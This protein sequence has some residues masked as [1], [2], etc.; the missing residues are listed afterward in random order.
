MSDSEKP[1]GASS[2]L[3]S[4]VD[5]PPNPSKVTS[6]GDQAGEKQN[7]SWS[8]SMKMS[9]HSD[10][11]GS[12][13]NMDQLGSDKEDNTNDNPDC[14][15][16]DGDM[17]DEDENE[18]Q[19]LQDQRESKNDSSE[20][21]EEEDQGD[22][23][24]EDE[25]NVETSQIRRES[26]D[27][28]SSEDGS[29]HSSNKESESNDEDGEFHDANNGSDGEEDN[30]TDD[31]E[32]PSQEQSPNQY[33]VP[34]NIQPGT[35]YQNVDRDSRGFVPPGTI[36]QNVDNQG[37]S[38]AT[39]EDGVS[40]V[41]PPQVKTK[42]VQEG[43][44]YENFEPP[45]PPVPPRDKK[46]PPIPVK[47]YRSSMP[48]TMDSV[49]KS[50]D[51]VSSDQENTVR[52]D[53]STPAGDTW[54]GPGSATNN[55]AQ[56]SGIY[57]NP[58]NTQNVPN[59]QDFSSSLYG[60]PYSKEK[61]TPADNATQQGQGQQP[62]GPQYPHIGQ[63]HETNRP[64]YQSMGPEGIQHQYIPG[65]YGPYHQ[66]HPT[67]N[68]EHGE[69]TT[70]GHYPS[71]PPGP[72]GYTPWG[73][74]SG[75]MPS[76]P[77]PDFAKNPEAYRQWCDYM[78]QMQ[79]Q[80]QR[81]WHQ[82]HFP[83]HPPPQEASSMP[84]Q[85]SQPPRDTGRGES[86]HPPVQKPAKKP[87]PPR[88]SKQK[89]KDTQDSGT[90]GDPG[91]KPKKKKKDQGDVIVCS[92][93]S[94]LNLPAGAAGKNLV[95][96]GGDQIMDYIKTNY[97][98]PIDMGEV[99]VV[100]AGNLQ[101]QELYLG[102]LPQ[103]HS[104]KGKP[105]KTMYVFMEKC[106]QL[107]DQS[108]YTTIIFSALGTGQLKYPKDQ[109]ANLMYQSIIDFDQ[110]N[111]S[112]VREVQIICFHG[113]RDTCTVSFVLK[114]FTELISIV[115]NDMLHLHVK[116]PYE[117]K[118]KVKMTIVKEEIGKHKADI[119]V[120]AV[121]K[122]LDIR[123]SGASSRSIYDNGGA[124]LQEECAS[125]YPNGLSN[126][127][128][129]A[130]ISGGNLHC[131]EVL[132]TALPNEETKTQKTLCKFVYNCMEYADKKG[133]KSIG[134]PAVGT[135]KINYDRNMVAKNFYSQV[136]KY[137]DDNP[138]SNIKDVRFV[139]YPKDEETI[140]V[141]AIVCCGTDDL[142]LSRGKAM[143]ALLKEGG[144]SLQQECKTKYPNGIQP[145]GV[146]VISGGNLKSSH[147]YLG[148]LPRYGSGPQEAENVLKDF[149]KKCL[150]T[151]EKNRLKSIAFPC[152]GSGFNS[153][154]HDKSAALLYEAVVDFDSQH[155]STSLKT[156]FFVALSNDT[157]SLTV[158]CS[159]CLRNSYK[160]N[161]YKNI[162]VHCMCM[163]IAFLA[164][165]DKNRDGF[166]KFKEDAIGQ[167]FHR[168]LQKFVAKGSQSSVTKVQIVA[169]QVT[170]VNPLCKA[171]REECGKPVDSGIL[172]TLS[173]IAENVG[174]KPRTGVI[175]SKKSQA[176]SVTVWIYSD[177]HR[178][179]TD[180][181]KELDKLVTSR[182][183]NTDIPDTL[184]PDLKQNEIDQIEDIADKY[185]IE[186]KIDVPRSK[187]LIEGP[188]KD[189][190]SAKDEIYK[191]FRTFQHERFLDD[192]A[193]HFATMVQ[194][195]I[196]EYEQGVC[197]LE[198]YP[199]RINM[200]LENAYKNN[201]TDKVTLNANDGDLIVDLQ[202]MKE[203]PVSDPS[204]K[205][206]VVRKELL[207]GAK[208]ELP[209][210]WLVMKDTETVKVV[211]LQPS[212]Q[213][214]Q[215][216]EKKFV[217]SVKN[218]VY[219]TKCGNYPGNKRTPTAADHPIGQ[220]NNVKVMKIERIQNPSLYQQYV[221]K[222]VSME[223]SGNLPPN[224]DPEKELW[225]GT[226]ENII[227]SINYY[228]FNRSYC[229]Q[230]TKQEA[231][232]GNGVYFASDASYS[233]RDWVSQKAAGGKKYMYL[234]KV[235][236]GDPVVGQKGMR[237]LPP[238]PGLHGVIY[239][240]AVDYIKSPMEYVI[241]NDTQAYPEYCIEFTI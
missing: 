135:G 11:N 141:D 39:P 161:Y 96:V 189:V 154:P 118:N 45:A 157:K 126:Y 20:E 65:Q 162:H 201:N 114:L 107:A 143:Q 174:L 111:T 59:P 91:K 73:M 5:A 120:C 79:M 88:Q 234:V 44:V 89:T 190:S 211:P 150:E 40:Q 197:K 198:H 10:D 123:G 24:D 125:K 146:A 50:S 84:P 194:W 175:G 127:G 215:H 52:S 241:F 148:T 3:G 87:D 137:S 92:T 66:Q 167:T 236:T 15:T 188:Q 22:V 145:R 221:A 57:K 130:T 173:S 86:P 205:A 235:L 156:V 216:I 171:M 108:G 128:D 71:M 2:D 172:G 163:Y 217:D 232:Y 62:T 229:S 27:E 41:P 121:T 196:M 238:K 214:Y 166:V 47:S 8:L 124:S 239:D 142:D 43:T 9:V 46:P 7:L 34:S 140:R 36:F 58:Y 195:S 206:D 49:G 237:V 230:N 177:S 85:T 134:F 18:V 23:D 144:E 32:I 223:S 63:G 30:Q 158:S 220:F 60:D 103:W 209:A 210:N 101:C 117:T 147:I 138:Q 109:A 29:I 228:G 168:A 240:S 213:E 176:S 54:Q 179:I 28:A 4:S 35:V 13:D 131:K 70:S 170:M 16:S 204:D 233:A 104:E 151:A 72:A 149:A 185:P 69:F 152:L 37:H 6:D 129:M 133:Y 100:D 208:I 203:Y 219:N 76:Y 53:S 132:L 83:Q 55:E 61:T 26:E 97:P 78:Q 105:K 68:T 191:L 64:Q 94:D 183:T 112:T 181:I 75:Y 159:V 193:E 56:K 33:Q 77:P 212:S 178:N 122:R 225:H 155:S 38:L 192:E 93:S 17:E 42:F 115:S 187:I 116:G 226:P 51:C 139:L 90:A 202:T 207:K 110:L 200:Q 21:E 224:T 48:I 136:K 184:I 186:M 19:T 74:Y 227:V 14:E 80:Y 231:W 1:S 12:D 164:L 153:Y 31:A 67:G 169:F 222:K 82:Q 119:L 180:A 102:S 218:G 113:D 182:F 165:S 98:S 106:L 81:A 99:A 25:D 95:T 199:K 160:I